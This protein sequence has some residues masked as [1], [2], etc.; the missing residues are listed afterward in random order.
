[1]PHF[2]GVLRVS[3]WAEQQVGALP[4]VGC[5]LAVLEG[6]C[7]FH[8]APAAKGDVVLGQVLKQNKKKFIVMTFF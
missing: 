2:L 8:P 6:A 3:S 5:S 7:C 4:Q 1:M